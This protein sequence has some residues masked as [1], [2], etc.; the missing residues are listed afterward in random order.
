MPYT[1]LTLEE[2]IVIELFVHMGMS[3]REIAAYL[4]RSHTTVSRE[5]R[6]NRSK[7]GYRSQTAERRARKRRNMPR[8]YRS[9]SRPE[10]LAYVDKKLRSDWS[11]EQIAGRI[12]LDYPQDQTMRISVETIYRWIYTAAQVGDTSYRHLRRAHKRRRGKPGTAEAGGFFPGALILTSAHRLLPTDPGMGTG[13]RI[14]SVPPGAR[15]RWSV[16]TNAK[17]VFWC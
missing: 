10:L 7:S 12:R 9:M 16:A 4:G 3:C 13:R 15:Q 17:A 1:H 6:R 2:R 14:L 11:P 5:L 8:H